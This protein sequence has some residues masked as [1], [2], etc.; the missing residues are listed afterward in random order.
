MMTTSVPDSQLNAIGCLPMAIPFVLLSAAANEAEAV[1]VRLFFYIFLYISVKSASHATDYNENQALMDKRHG[2]V[3]LI[4][5]RWCGGTIVN[6]VNFK[7]NIGETKHCC[8]VIELPT[9]SQQW[10]R[11]FWP[12]TKCLVWTQPS[13]R[14]TLCIMLICIILH[15]SLN[16]HELKYQKIWFDT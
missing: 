3:K 2:K 10:I 16:K 1:S 5:R 14:Q 4:N 12:I 7:Q 9:T 8:E 13:V 6:D 15:I 11:F